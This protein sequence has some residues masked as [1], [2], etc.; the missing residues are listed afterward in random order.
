MDSDG[1]IIYNRANKSHYIVLDTSKDEWIF[2]ERVK[3]I[4]YF[5]LGRERKELVIDNKGGR[6]L[7]YQITS[8][9]LYEYLY[10]LRNDPIQKRKVIEHNIWAIRMYLLGFTDGDGSKIKKRIRI[11]NSNLETIKYIVKLLSKIGINLSEREIKVQKRSKKYI[12]IRGRP[13]SGD[14]EFLNKIIKFL[15]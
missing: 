10:H 11:S 6:R 13:K 4:L 7:R 9:G 14:R 12:I 1:S 3:K 15:G 5:L 8:R 2:I